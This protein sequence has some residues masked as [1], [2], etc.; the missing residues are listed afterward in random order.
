VSNDLQ[1]LGNG[2]FFAWK[3]GVD[4]QSSFEFSTGTGTSVFGL[5]N[6]HKTLSNNYP[7]FLFRVFFCVFQH[8]IFVLGSCLIL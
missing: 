1:L 2:A 3:N 5:L 7:L 8:Q 4:D 6:T